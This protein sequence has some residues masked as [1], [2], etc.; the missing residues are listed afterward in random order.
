MAT[1]DQDTD[2][3]KTLIEKYE[4]MIEKTYDPSMLIDDSRPYA[5]T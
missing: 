2:E 3:F 5:P 4:D 1:L